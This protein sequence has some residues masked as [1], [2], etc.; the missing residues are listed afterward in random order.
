M[1][2]ED[3]IPVVRGGRREAEPDEAYQEAR[4]RDDP[5]RKRAEADLLVDEK[6]ENQ[7]KGGAG[8]LDEQRELINRHQSLYREAL[9]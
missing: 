1:V 4:P 8:R 2:Q 7:Q 9:I 6:E 5:L 3:G